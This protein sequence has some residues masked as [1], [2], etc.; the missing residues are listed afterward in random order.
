MT[1]EFF[2]RSGGTEVVLTHVGLA[3]AESRDNHQEGWEGTLE[4]LAA[5]LIR[6]QA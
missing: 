4:R 2:E 3:D 6:K 5:D 1:V